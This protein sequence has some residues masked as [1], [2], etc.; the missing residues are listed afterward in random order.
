MRILDTLRLP[1][2]AATGLLGFDSIV[3][4]IA[5]LGAFVAI[6]A[7]LNCRISLRNGR[8][9]AI[10]GTM[11][12][13]RGVRCAATSVLRTVVWLSVLLMVAYLLEVTGILLVAMIAGE[14]GT[15][16]SYRTIITRVIF[17]AALA[18]TAWL[19]LKR[20]KDAQ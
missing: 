13:R 7:A 18:G 4:T 15:L 12:C 17:V 16:Q 14:P 10:E 9:E 19:I 20:P 11:L 6:V 5:V 1:L 2:D 8:R 3:P